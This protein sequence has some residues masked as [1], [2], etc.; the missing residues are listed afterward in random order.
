MN[1]FEQLK[2]KIS[3]Q[4]ITLVFPEEEDSRIQ[5]AAVRLANE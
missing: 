5:G 4:H 1:I 2:S 3:D